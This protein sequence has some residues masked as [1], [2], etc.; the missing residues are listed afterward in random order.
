MLIDCAFE[1]GGIKGL[2][3]VGVIEYFEDNNFKIHKAV[4]TSVGAI[5]AS[6]VA[7]KFNAKEIK[8]IIANIDIKNLKSRNKL[9]PLIKGLGINNI[10]S[11]EETLKNILE[12]KNI[13]VFKDLKFGNDYLLKVITT[14]WKTRSKVVIP[15]D[16]PKYNIDKDNF[17]VAK[18]VAM[19]CTLPFV[20]SVYEYKGYKFLDGGLTNKFPID[21]LKDSQNP[22]IGLKIGRSDK[23]AYINKNRTI[24]KAHIINIDTLGIKASQFVKGLFYKEELYK[25]G[26][27][28]VKNYFH[29]I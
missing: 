24:N 22:I 21:L 16:L 10:Y 9:T 18:A 26:Y 6:L 28:S 27:I 4:G 12:K 17:E 8:Q 1:G 15:D 3:Y 25:A 7:S 11:L 19:S 14:D 2:A 13:K 5:F 23:I 20:Y 29:K